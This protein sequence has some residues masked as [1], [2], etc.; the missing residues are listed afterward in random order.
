MSNQES[1]ID[2]RDY[3]IP[4]EF[5]D[6]G[7]T[8]SPDWLPHTGEIRS[9]CRVHDYLYS[10]GGTEVDRAKAD[11]VLWYGI[12]LKGSEK[13][14]VNKIFALW[15]AFVYWRSVRRLGSFFFNYK[16]IDG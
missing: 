12:V 15:S 3:Q 10:V 7:C 5:K 1:S 6:N 13:G 9:V 4:D 8:F 16:K 2:Y 11:A 14:W